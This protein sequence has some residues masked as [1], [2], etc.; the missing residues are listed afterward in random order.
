M[1]LPVCFCLFLVHVFH[2]G[3]PPFFPSSH[4]LSIFLKR[5]EKRMKK[6]TNHMFVAGTS[7]SALERSEGVSYEWINIH[8]EQRYQFFMVTYP[9]HTR[10]PN[11]GDTLRLRTCM[12]ESPWSR[13]GWIRR[14]IVEELWRGLIKVKFYI[15][16]DTYYIHVSCFFFIVRT[17]CFEMSWI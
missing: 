14:I 16:F 12:E 13:P 3:P 10:T 9:C 15:L 4:Y 8:I 5:G 11:F 6:A 1:W 2:P 17:Y 7:V